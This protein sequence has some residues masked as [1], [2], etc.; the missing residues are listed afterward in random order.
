[1]LERI[2]LSN[3]RC[4]QECTIDFD[5]FNVLVGKNN[6]GKSTLIDTPKLISNVLRYAAY[7]RTYLEDRDI[8][9]S[10]TNF[11]A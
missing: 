4:F 6:S 3:F 7:R 8:P 11:E 1:M 2:E 10:L 5:K 9:F